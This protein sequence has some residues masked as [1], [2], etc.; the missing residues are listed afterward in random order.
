MRQELEFRINS[1]EYKAGYLATRDYLLQNPKGPDGQ[2][3]ASYTGMQ[4]QRV[5]MISEALNIWRRAA[6]EMAIRTMAPED[7]KRLEELMN[8]DEVSANNLIEAYSSID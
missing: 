4:D 2:K 8:A 5:Q 6:V 7:K 1:K 3:T